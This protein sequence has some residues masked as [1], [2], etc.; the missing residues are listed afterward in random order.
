MDVKIIKTNRKRNG[1]VSGFI[2]EARKHVLMLFLFLLLFTGLL[3]GNFIVNG[4]EKIYNSIGDIFQSY[5]D[6]LDG[7]TFLRCFL[8]NAIINA[9]I[10]FINF[11]FGLCAVGFPV[12]L[13]SVLIKGLSIGALSSYLYTSFALKGFGYCMLV[14]YP[15]QII[16]CLILLKTGQDSFK[17]SISLLKILNERRQNSN[18]GTEFN[19]YLLKF[20]I[21]ISISTIL[22]LITAVMTV[23]ITKL[24]NF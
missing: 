8:Q 2:F 24:F 15:V 4:N 21:T 13:I 20:I 10:L 16:A 23:Y 22:S 5:I 6:S 7:Q 14:V 9:G 1:H 19:Q 11:I 17:M 18:E 12:P 3:L